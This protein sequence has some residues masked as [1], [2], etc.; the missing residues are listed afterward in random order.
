MK[1]FYYPNSDGPLIPR[2]QEYYYC[3]L[4]DSIRSNH[5]N[6]S[7]LK[8][9]YSIHMSLEGKDTIYTVGVNSSAIFESDEY[10][11]PA[12]FYIFSPSRGFWLSP[13]PNTVK[14]EYFEPA[15]QHQKTQNYLI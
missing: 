6:I 15:F 2:E 9:V 1:F 13:P 11:Q 8:R 3:Y 5:K 7:V 14:I 4:Q 12:S 10:I